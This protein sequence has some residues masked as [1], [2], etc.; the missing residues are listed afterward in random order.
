MFNFNLKTISHTLL[1]G[2]H[3][4]YTHSNNMYLHVFIWVTCTLSFFFLL[5][6]YA[7]LFSSLFIFLC[8]KIKVIKMGNAFS[9][10]LIGK[11]LLT[12][13]WCTCILGRSRQKHNEPHIRIIIV[14]SDYAIGTHYISSIFMFARDVPSL[15]FGLLFS[16]DC[17][18][19]TVY[20]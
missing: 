8:R 1:K 5:Q 7:H 6:S 9:I 4:H 17:Q 11:G 13:A 14:K 19:D 20:S 3:T 18:D 2:P 12:L 10:I 15:D 16:L